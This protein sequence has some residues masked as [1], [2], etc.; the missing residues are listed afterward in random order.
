MSGFENFGDELLALEERL[1]RLALA[2]G[3]DLHV[4]SVVVSLIR[5]DF[6][7]CGRGS[8]PKRDEL[9]A[10]LMLKYRVESTC[11]DE[12]GAHDCM[13][14]VEQVD[15]DLARRGFPKHAD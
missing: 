9:R 1:E 2:C 4:R 12:L 5:G 11:I 8:F 15:A 10:L 13:R 6:A 7:V 14:I 3:V